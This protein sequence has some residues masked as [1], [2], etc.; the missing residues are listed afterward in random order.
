M[1]IVKRVQK[2]WSRHESVTDVMTDGRTDGRM[3]FLLPPSALRWGLIKIQQYFSILNNLYEMLYINPAF[4]I[5]YMSTG[6]SSVLALKFKLKH[7]WF[8]S[9]LGAKYCLLNIH[10]ECYLFYMFLYCGPNHPM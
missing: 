5:F 2:I 8:Q 9:S 10:Y 3:T 1:K 7:H 4:V 6:S